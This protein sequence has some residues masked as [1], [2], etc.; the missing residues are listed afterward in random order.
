MNLE[1]VKSHVAGVP[2]ILDEMASDLYFFIM[3]EQPFECLEL[4]FG[5]GASSCYIAGALDELGRGKLTSVDLFSGL[6][7]QTPSIEELLEKTD[8]AHR[9]EIHREQTGYTWFLK[10]Q[11]EKQTFNN[12]CSPIYDFCFIDGAK[13]WTTDAAAFFLV[14]KLMKPGGWIVFDDL[15]WKFQRKVNEGKTKLDGISLSNMGIKELTQPHIELVFKL[16]VMQHPDYSHFRIKDEWWAWA[17]KVPGSKEVKYE[18]SKSFLKGAAISEADVVKQRPEPLEAKLIQDL[19]RGIDPDNK[20]AIEKLLNPKKLS[21]G[22]T[23]WNQF[24]ASLKKVNPK[25]LEGPILDFGC[26]VGHFVLEGLNRNMDIWGVDCL[27]GKVS[28]YKRLVKLTSNKSSW[29]ERCILGSGENLPFKSNKFSAIS[30]WFVFEHIAEPLPVLKELMRVLKSNGVMIIRAEDA[31]TSWE[32]HCKIPWLPYL[33]EQYVNVWLEEFDCSPDLR[34]GV[35]NITLPECETFLEELG[36]RII[37]KATEPLTPIE[38][39]C[40]LPTEK[41]I[42]FK[43]RQ[44]KT[45]LNQGAWLPQPK[46]FHICAQKLY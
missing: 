23:R 22:H 14:D 33:S 30:S 40:D 10:K 41:K 31:R 6:E 35:Y 21:K 34:N 12:Q 37:L 18:Y 8:L 9:V 2:Y 7:W 44:A 3:K 5:H 46:Y 15:R 24:S 25:S 20:Y 39:H 29:E 4:G 36:C 19:N 45:L 27:P 32:A 26:G 17:K 28:R 1:T 16:L 38:N 11:I 13:H 42:R 43:A